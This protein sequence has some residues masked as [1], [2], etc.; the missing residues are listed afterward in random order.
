MIAHLQNPIGTRRLQW[1]TIVTVLMLLSSFAAFDALGRAADP[2]QTTDLQGHVGSGGTIAVVRWVHGSVEILLPKSRQTDG[3]GSIPKWVQAVVGMQLTPGAVVRTGKDA[4]VELAYGGDARILVEG[5]TEVSVGA[6]YPAGKG[7]GNR[8][9]GSARE[10]SSA[11]LSV[12][13]GKIWVHVRQKVWRLL[14]FSVETPAAVAAVRGTLFQVSVASNGVTRVAVV[15]GLVGARG[16]VGEE[17]G[18]PAG[19]AVTVLPG[20]AVPSPVSIGVGY[21]TDWA[22]AAR[23]IKEQVA[24]LQELKEDLAAR[25]ADTVPTSGATK[26]GSGGGL[27]S[28][29]TESVTQLPSQLTGSTP[30]NQADSSGIAVGEGLSRSEVEE[31]IQAVDGRIQRVQELLRIL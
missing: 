5:S 31:A 27:V 14:H 11:T 29:A 9:V 4:W 18:V 22:D 16:T 3:K 23:W 7:S 20:K 25:L 21:R 28:G 13:L 15:E 24:W 12:K 19:K 8:M 30:G 26:K 1:V 2:S 6:L 10:G 17:I